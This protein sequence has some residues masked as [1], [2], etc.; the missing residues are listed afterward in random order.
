MLVLTR[1]QGQSIIINDEIE[2]MVVSTKGNQ[3]RLGIK[4]P[5]NVTINRKE[6]QEKINNTRDYTLNMLKIMEDKEQTVQ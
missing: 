5:N 4:A 6:I 3:I 1:K 2:I